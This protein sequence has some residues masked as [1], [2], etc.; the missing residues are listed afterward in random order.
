VIVAIVAVGVVTRIDAAAAA[1]AA[2]AVVVVAV[3][4]GK[5]H[6]A[7]ESLRCCEHS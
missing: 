5:S 2:A 1:A 6:V 4:H 3:S 7:D